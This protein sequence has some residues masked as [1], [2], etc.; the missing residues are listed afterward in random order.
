MK[1]N[2]ALAIEIEKARQ[3]KIQATLIK[4]I[5]KSRMADIIFE[6]QLADTKVEYL[7]NKLRNERENVKVQITLLSYKKEEMKNL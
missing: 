2:K 5:V 3:E 6:I 1:Y 4:D 7:K